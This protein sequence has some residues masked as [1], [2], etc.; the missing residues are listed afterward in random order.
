MTTTDSPILTGPAIRTL[1]HRMGEAADNFLA[2]LTP[3]QKVKAACPFS[4]EE[5]RTF[6]HYTPIIR[7]GLTL[8]EMEFQQR[9]LA[10]KLVATGVSRTGYAAV[11][12]IIGLETT[13]DMYEGWGSGKWQRNPGNYYMSVFGTPGTVEPWGWKFEGHHVSLNYTIVNGQIVS[14][15]PTFFG[16]NPADAAL[17]GVSALR[18][19][20]NVED[21]ARD[22]VHNLSDQQRDTAILADQAPKDILT[23]NTP[24]VAEEY[25]PRDQLDGT[26]PA[27]FET[28][29]YTP[30]PKGLDAAGMQEPQRE[31]LHALITEYIH[32]MPDVIAQIESDRLDRRGLDGI[33]LAWS[34]G[35]EKRQGHYY[36][37]Q[38]PRF[39]VEYDNIQNDANHIHSVWRDP[40]NDFG[41]DLLARHYHEKH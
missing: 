34:G 33:H 21:L 29:R 8:E 14:P 20:G 38:G 39:L 11:S 22:L 32:R 7:D 23:L 19:I 13:L 16:A 37:L 10:H 40:S 25:H 5:R 4:E 28:V 27:L 17:N 6:W 9:R 3:D 15:T 12:A 41:A 26:D 18:P 36:R 31:I 35:I 24:A 30:K 2:C 1:V